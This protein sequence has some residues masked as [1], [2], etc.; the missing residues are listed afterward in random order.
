MAQNPWLGRQIQAD[1]APFCRVFARNKPSALVRWATGPK[2]CTVLRKKMGQKIFLMGRVGQ[3]VEI[4]VSHLF[5][6]HRTRF[7]PSE[8][9]TNTLGLD[10]AK[11]RQNDFRG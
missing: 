9:H 5:A 3:N 1:P 8:N 4:S 6:E 10:R 7:C 2:I 11:T